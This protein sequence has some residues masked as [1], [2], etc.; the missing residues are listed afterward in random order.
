MA[1]SNFKSLA[2]QVQLGTLL[3]YP[4]FPSIKCSLVLGFDHDDD[5]GRA[6]FRLRDY[7]SL[8][9]SVDL[10]ESVNEPYII[11]SQGFIE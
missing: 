1:K 8:Y 10:E 11:H 2:S 5:T 7:G 6:I 4:Q 9:L 3:H